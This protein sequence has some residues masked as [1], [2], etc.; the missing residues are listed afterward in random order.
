[1]ISGRPFPS[2]PFGMVMYPCTCV[3]SRAVNEIGRIGD[4]SS[5]LIQLIADSR[6]LAL[7]VCRSNR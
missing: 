3:P 5:G 7:P 1:M 4:I 6:N 2:L